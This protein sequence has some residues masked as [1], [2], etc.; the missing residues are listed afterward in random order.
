MRK[1][2][3]G[4]VVS[5]VLVLFLLAGCGEKENGGQSFD[6]ISENSEDSAV[7]GA[8]GDMQSVS[9]EEQT[10]YVREINSINFER[11]EEGYKVSSVFY[12]FMDGKV[13]MFRMEIPD[14]GEAAGKQRVCMQ[15]YETTEKKVERY[16]LTPEIPGHDEYWISSA[17]L[18]DQG[19]ISFKMW[20]KKGEENFYFAV[21][22]DM[23]GKVLE[24]TEPFPEEEEYPWNVEVFSEIRTFHLQDGRTV[25]SRWDEAGQTSVLTWFGGEKAGQELGRLEGEKPGALCIGE[26]GALYCLAGDSLICWDTEKDL[27]EELFCL[28]E[29]GV[30]VSEDSGLFMADNGDLVMCRI[31]EGEALAYVLT[32]EEITYDEKI[33]LSWMVDLGEP[34]RY[35]AKCAGNYARETGGLPVTLEKEQAKYYEDYRN[36]IF[37]EL[38]VGR[39]PDILYLTREDLQLL[40]EKGGLCDLSGMIPEEVKEVMIPAALELGVVDGTMVGFTPQVEFLSLMTAERIWAEESWS[41]DEFLETAESVEDWEI[42]IWY[43]GGDLAGTALL[44]IL[45]SDTDNTSLLDLEQGISYLNSEKFMRILELCKKR[46]QNNRE[47]DRAEFIDLMKEGKGMAEWRWISDLSSFSG[48]M[49]SYGEGCNLVGYPSE[50]GSGNYARAGYPYGYLAVNANSEHKD[51]IGKFFAYLLDYDKQFSVD[52]CSVRMDVICDSVLYDP[53]QGYRMRISDNPENMM[54]RSLDVKEDGSTWLDEY[55]EFLENCRPQPFMPQQISRIIAEEAEVYYKGDKSA[56]ETADII[57][58][59]VQLYLEEN[60]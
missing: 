41:L 57:H 5:F 34:T 16:V 32:D 17:G 52:G 39:G 4:A 59:R 23:Q 35:F 27:K 31:N 21:K 30:A 47:T 37:A 1:G 54:T 28:H 11:P 24:V 3:I 49:E 56:E 38:A 60:R 18:T 53:I 7:S 20:E 8:V 55:L 19:E 25:V 26:A 45:M 51:E 46:G 12:D 6:G 43:L 44:D 13:W 40:A 33:R 29:N 9:R 2:M 42:M 15:I 36:R 10:L 50:G 22:T 48:I 14:E 58:R